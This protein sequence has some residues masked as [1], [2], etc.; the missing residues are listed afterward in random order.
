VP[1]EIVEVVSRSRSLSATAMKAMRDWQNRIEGGPLHPVECQSTK[2]LRDSPLS[3]L[4]TY[5]RPTHR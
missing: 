2:S 5:Q 1:S 3:G 4:L